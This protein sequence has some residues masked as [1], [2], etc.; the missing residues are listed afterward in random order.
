M[1]R[2]GD[3]DSVID[4]YKRGIDRPLLRESLKLTIE[5]RFEQLVQLQRFAAEMS[6]AGRRA[7]HDRL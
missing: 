2:I 3:P 5:Q 6:R 4:A 1:G 7:A